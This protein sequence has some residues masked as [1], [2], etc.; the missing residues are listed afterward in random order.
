M[1]SAANLLSL[2]NLAAGSDSAFRTIFIL[3]SPLDWMHHL[4]EAPKSLIS[5][6]P[7]VFWHQH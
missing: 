2:L 7:P 4:R 1:L 5:S 3:S 6:L